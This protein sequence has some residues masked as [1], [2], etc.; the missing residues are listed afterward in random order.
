MP[1]IVGAL[2]RVIECMEKRL[3]ELK[4]NRYYQ[5]TALLKSTRIFRGVLEISEGLLSLS[6][7]WMTSNLSRSKTF[8]KNKS[9]K[10]WQL[11]FL[12]YLCNE[13]SVPPFNLFYLDIIKVM[14]MM[15]MMMTFVLIAITNTTTKMVF[16]LNLRSLFWIVVKLT[17]CS[18][19]DSL[20]IYLD[21]WTYKGKQRISIILQMMMITVMEIMMMEI[22]KNDFRCGVPMFVVVL[23]GRAR[24]MAQMVNG[25]CR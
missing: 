14:M 18:L 22:I 8:S 2:G 20:G 12:H 16:K 3:G 6:L 25:R 1:V 15:I 13:S 4:K 10:I 11:K 17:Q 9:N 23:I 24:V 5:T 19:P 7:R 21:L